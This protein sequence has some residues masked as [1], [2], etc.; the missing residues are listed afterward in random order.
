M[1]GRLLA[2][3][4]VPPQRGRTESVVIVFDGGV[5]YLENGVQYPG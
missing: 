5:V 2:V 4:W 3:D 1:V